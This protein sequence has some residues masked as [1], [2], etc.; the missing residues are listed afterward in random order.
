MHTA[1]HSRLRH[2]RHVDEDIIRRV[3]VQRC[4]QAFLVQMVTNETDAT[5]KNE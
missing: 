1:Q 4:T 2:I 3:T 5:S